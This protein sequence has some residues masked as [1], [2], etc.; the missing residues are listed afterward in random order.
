MMIDWILRLKNKTIE[1]GS[2]IV[3]KHLEFHGGIEWGWIALL[4]LAF[5]V[6]VVIAYRW[7]PA[8]QSVGRKV[9][10]VGL[11]V[12]FILL[13]VGILLRPILALDISSEIRQTLLVLIDTSGSMSITDPRVDAADIK[14]A[15]IAKGHLDPGRGLQQELEPGRAEEFRL[16]ARTNVL[17]GVLANRQLDL[18]PALS[19]KFDLVAFTFGR[20]GQVRE[21]PRVEPVSG[22]DPK[23]G[24]VRLTP[25][26][27]KWIEKLG[28]EHSATAL[29]DSLREVLKRKRGQPL[30]GVLVISDGAHNTGTQPLAVSA[31]LN[32]A[33]LPLFFY[34]VGITSPRDI[35]I[36]EMD[37][38]AAAFIEDE[39]LVQVRV[40]SQGLAGQNGQLILTLNG[41][42][43]AEQTIAFGAD[44]E[45]LV[46][47]RIPTTLAG[48]F[49][50]KASIA[51]RDDETDPDNNSAQRRLRIVDKKIKV[52]FVE[53]S[54]RW[55]YRYL[56]A[57]L[58]RDRRV[59]VKTL[60]L[61][62]DPALAR[63]ED[64]PYLEKFPE[65][66]KELFEYD[67]V[68][69]GDVDPAELSANQKENLNEFVSRFGGAF[70]MIAGRNFSPLAYGGT[71]I[72]DMLPV[73]FEA[74]SSPNGDDIADQPIHVQLTALGRVDP[75]LNLVRE[76]EDNQVL[77][78]DLPPIYWVAPVEAKPGAEVLMVDPSHSTPRGKRPIIA[79]HQYGLGQ[80]LFVG[81]DNTWRWRRNVGDLYYTRFWGQVSQRM[82]QQRFIGADKRTQISLNSQNY[83][84]G[85]DRVRAY[86]RLY[87]EGYEPFDDEEVHAVY[88][89]ADGQLGRVILQRVEG[90]KGL[91][92]GEFLAPAVGQYQ[93]YVEPEPD[94]RRDFTVV[95]TSVE[96][97]ETAMNAPLMQE[98]AA[99]S[100]S[101]FSGEQDMKNVPGHDSAP[102]QHHPWF[103]REEDLHQLAGAIPAR[104]VVVISQLEIELWDDFLLFGLILLVVT[105]EWVLRKFSYLK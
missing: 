34:G 25:G 99:L 53:Q 32:E 63:V 55:D 22:A 43:V 10:L 68:I 8:E 40:R 59:E 14:R 66:K 85:E 54:P 61:E 101:R 20:G 11:R 96:L 42:Q 4:L 67:V 82:A 88:E 18:L 37:A 50:L 17:Q 24:P 49:E 81:T 102:G 56:Q 105:V 78:K 27:F 71:K 89:S 95:Q 86:A 103:F 1:P 36:T 52:L 92:Y 23:A 35:I 98:L 31:E 48:E 13:L 5:A 60:L 21:L 91:F 44:G 29:G 7:L 39:L 45:Q 84:A 9:A 12:V 38:P 83:M 70:V 47:L 76:G 41:A 6:V 73:E 2:E 93:F 97:A 100:A 46:R 69:F 90:Q 62:G 72:A 3:G 51:A 26:D 64:S 58:A 16:L 79:R 19:E 74:R 77:W 87:Q 104:P 30:A 65:N 57:M 28:A 33:G 15:A 94:T 75:M 80:V